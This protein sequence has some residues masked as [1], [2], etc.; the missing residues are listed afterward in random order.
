MLFHQLKQSRKTI[1][2]HSEPSPYTEITSGDPAC[3][4]RLEFHTLS[5]KDNKLARRVKERRDKNKVGAYEEPTIEDRLARIDEDI[6]RLKI[7]F[8]VYFNGGT[9]RPPYDTKARVESHLKRMGD[10]RTLN[11]AQRYHYNSLATRYASFRE[12]WRRTLQ[13]REEGRDAAAAA[14]AS[15]RDPTAPFTRSEFSC[16]DVRHDV[17]TVKGVYDALM[18]AKRSCGEATRDLSF[19]KFHRL[20]LER[21]ENLKEKIGVDRVVFSVEV[22]GGHVSF[23]AKADG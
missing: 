2:T 3:A 18:E 16:T 20:V 12:M 7:E 8:D 14:R 4:A 10:D 17:R 6:R 5:L 19:A 11:F 9:K 21:T 1:L 13:S 22:E 15:Q 23:K